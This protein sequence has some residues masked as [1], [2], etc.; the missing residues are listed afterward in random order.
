MVVGLGR[1]KEA[2]AKVKLIFGTGKFIITNQ[3]N[4]DLNKFL[5]YR[6]I[7]SKPLEDLGLVKNYNI[8]VNVH[9]GGLKGQT[10]AIKLGIA[11]AISNLDP[12]YRGPLKTRGHLTR[13]SRAKER[14]KYGLKKARKASQFSK[15]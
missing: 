4:F 13:D 7:A 9:G 3:L 10:E 12:S 5:V 2:V 8:I 15:R 1:R 11:R 6:S 14:R